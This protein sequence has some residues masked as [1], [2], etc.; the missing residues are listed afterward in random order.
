M[1]EPKFCDRTPQTLA[2]GYSPIPLG[3][4]KNELQDQARGD[5]S[6]AGKKK[7]PYMGSKLP[8]AVIRTES[9]GEV[10]QP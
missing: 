3:E 4:L 1:E 6:M 8:C 7:L 2:P 10:E 9:F 5:F